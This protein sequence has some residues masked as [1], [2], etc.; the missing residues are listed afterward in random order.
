MKRKNISAT[1]IKIKLN[2]T[3]DMLK[4]IEAVYQQRTPIQENLYLT[5]NKVCPAKQVA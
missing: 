1:G 4:G 3:K 2:L 5:F